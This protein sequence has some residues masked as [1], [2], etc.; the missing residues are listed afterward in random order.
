MK[1]RTFENRAFLVIVALVTVAFLWM[2]R[3]FLMPVFWAAVLGVLFHGVYKGWLTMMPGWRN[4]AALLTVITAVLVVIVPLILLGIAV[5]NEV[6]ALYHRLA[7][8]VVD[9]QA[10]I[11]WLQEQVPIVADY[12]ERYGVDPDN[13]RQWATDLVG[14]VS[15]FL[16]AQALVLGRDAAQFLA[17]FFLMLYVLFFFVRDGERIVQLL[18]RALPLGDAREERL[19]ERFVVVARATTKGTLVVAAVQGA[20]GGILLWIVGIQGALLWAVLM[21]ILALLPVVGTFLVWGPAAIYL[22]SVGQIG[23]AIFVFLGGFFVVGTADNLLRPRL[24]GR[25]TRMPDY[26][27]LLATLGG[28][29]KFGLSGFVLGP[30]LAAFFLVVWDLFSEEFGALDRPGVAPELEPDPHVPGPGNPPLGAEDVA[31]GGAPA[32]AAEAEATD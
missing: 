1:L 30:M 3:P 18:I 22:L 14:T 28:L 4:A 13:V 16:A 26:I 10:P 24:V 21:A 20:L 5:T 29:V 32:V 27:V 31:A 25:D 23:A 17:M 7:V 12:L 15:Q 9:V 8:G 6:I 19:F 11:L 2:V